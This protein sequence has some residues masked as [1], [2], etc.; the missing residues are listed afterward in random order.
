MGRSKKK[1]R[2]MILLDTNIVIYLHGAQLNNT[3]LATLQSSVLSTCNIIITEVLESKAIDSTDAKYFE[4]LFATMKNYPFDKAVT[5]KVIELRRTTS[6]KL[7]DAIIA[8][9]ALVNDLVLWTHNIDDFK[10]VSGLQIFDPI[11]T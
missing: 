11:S 2:R 3:V 4:N 1:E 7:P 9:T 6:I 5:N 8:A 10:H